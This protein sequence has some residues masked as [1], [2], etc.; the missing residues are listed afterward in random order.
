MFPAIR[1]YKTH[2]LRTDPVHR[3]YLEESG[4][5]SGEPLLFLHGGPGGSSQPY[6][7]RFC[8]PKFF[9][10]IQ[11]DQRGC[12]KSKPLG[13]LKGNTTQS[14]MRDMEKIRKILRIEKWAICGGSWG[15]TLALAYAEKFPHR[16]S[17]LILR[18]VFLGTSEEVNWAFILSAKKYR[19]QLWKN[20]LNNL[21][22]DEQ[23]DPLASYQKRILGSNRK[24]KH[25][26]SWVWHDYERALSTAQNI[27]HLSNFKMVA[28]RKKIPNSPQLEC[29]YIR[30]HFFLTQN[31]ILKRIESIKH[32]PGAIIHGQQDLLCHPKNARALAQKWKRAKLHL[33]PKA[34]HNLSE[35]GMSE[36]VLQAIGDLQR[37]VF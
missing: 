10:I 3:I 9:R 33:V 27:I 24:L 26:A 13:Q 25:T 17:A 37:N 7:R 30:N 4:N 16:V 34:G 23:L 8:D 1:S 19:P 18:S 11:F 29:H 14:L 6:I 15:S 32:V 22:L 2:F 5:S 20:F 31:P 21:P 28:R 36:A 35:P 12:G